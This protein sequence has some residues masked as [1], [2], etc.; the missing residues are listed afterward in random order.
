MAK[1]KKKTL[2]LVSILIVLSSQILFGTVQTSWQPPSAPPSPSSVWDPWHTKAQHENRMKALCNSHSVA[3]YGSIGK[4]LDGSDIWLYKIGNPNGGTIFW[5]GALH[6]VEDYSSE[7][8]YLMALWLLESGDTR[9]N[10][11][12]Q[13]NLVLFIPVVSVTYDRGN[14]NYEECPYGVNLNRNFETGWRYGGLVPNDPPHSDYSG[15]YPA[16]E[17]ETQ[18][19]KWVFKTYRPEHYV[20]L[21]QGA[22]ANSAYYARCPSSEVQQVIS[23]VYQVA[24]EFEVSPLSMHRMGSWGFAI[25]DA[26]HDGGSISW[27]IEVSDSWR[28]D[29][30]AWNNELIPAF[31][32]CLVH[33]IA[34][35]ECAHTGS[36]MNISDMVE[37]AIAFGSKP[38]DYNWNPNVDHNQDG[39]IDISDLVFVALRLGEPA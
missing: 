1:M 37:V 13:E 17:L 8:V 20:N 27:L 7:I 28:H 33:F 4:R 16:S 24:N 34:Q 19:I 5:D 25:G 26:Y 39:I 29:T 15:P 31:W 10:A 21:H 12:L 14:L 35:C 9:A 32:K 2:F 30:A 18:A 3:S 23:E 6:G 36:S 22:R 38:G 11:I